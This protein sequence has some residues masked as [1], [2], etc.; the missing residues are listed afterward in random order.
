[1]K[2]GE[3]QENDRP[4]HA[5]GRSEMMWDDWITKMD[6]DYYYMTFKKRQ[7]TPTRYFE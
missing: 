3:D 5:V 4:A 6:K 2:K 1:M 7:A